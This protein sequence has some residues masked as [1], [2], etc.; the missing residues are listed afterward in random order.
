MVSVPTDVKNWAK[1]AFEMKKVGLKWVNNKTALLN[2]V[3]NKNYEKIS[4]K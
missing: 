4:V 3:F 2:K 1:K